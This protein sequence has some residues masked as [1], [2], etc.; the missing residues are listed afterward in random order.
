MAKD[1]LTQEDIK[2]L[3]EYLAQM[4]AKMEAGEEVSKSGFQKWLEKLG[5]HYLMDKLA[6]AWEFILD[7]IAVLF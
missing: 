1:N 4:K 6:D 2:R 3:E 5:F 7:V